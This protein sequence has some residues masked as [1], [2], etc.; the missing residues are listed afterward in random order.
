MKL[1]VVI[2]N[3]NAAGLTVKCLKSIE[4][5]INKFDKEIIV[6]DNNSCQND[7]EKMRDTGVGGLK[8]IHLPN[9]MGFGLANNAGVK[10]AT[11]EMVLLLNSDTE[12]MDYNIND[13]IDDFYKNKSKALWGFKLLWPGG[14]FQNSFIREIRFLDFVLSYTSIAYCS[15]FIHRIRYHKYYG[16]PVNASLKVPVVYA[17]AMLCW[18]RDFCKLGGFDKKYFMYFEDIDFCDRFQDELK[19]EIYYYPGVS[20]IHHVKG[21]QIDDR[22]INIQYIKSKYL[23][24]LH[25]FNI[26]RMIPFICLDVMLTLPVLC[27]K[28][29]IK[30]V[31]SI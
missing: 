28:K 2:V 6:V 8:I 26:F 21:S 14:A 22:L 9:N 7:I 23:Y 25:K 24:G 4:K 5:Y 19:G 18:R 16:Q 13:A 1:S 29:T 3:Y 17:T 12:L 31:N 15:R 20:L 30:L 27:F 10:N 11:G